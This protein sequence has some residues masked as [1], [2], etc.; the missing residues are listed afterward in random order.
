MILPGTNRNFIFNAGAALLY[1]TVLFLLMLLNQ[2]K[3]FTYSAILVFI[4]GIHLLFLIAFAILGMLKMKNL[5]P[6]SGSLIA[7]FALD[8]VTWL[9]IFILF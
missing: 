9:L 1:N 5:V 2:E 4:A 8:F 3:L 6:L 7:V